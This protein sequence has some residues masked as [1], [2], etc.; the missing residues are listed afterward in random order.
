VEKKKILE[1]FQKILYFPLQFYFSENFNIFT[2][3]IISVE[4]A[5][6][7]NS[8]QPI[9]PSVV[10][11]QGQF[12]HIDRRTSKKAVLFTCKKVSMDC[13]F[14]WISGCIHSCVIE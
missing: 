9:Q 11:V 7:L 3:D 5:N 2:N 14:T 8:I 10:M 13:S 6:V 4:P 1:V 12:Q